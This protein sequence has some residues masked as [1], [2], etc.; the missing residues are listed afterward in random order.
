M[1]KVGEADTE[2]PSLRYDHVKAWESSV[3]SSIDVVDDKVPPKHGP[4]TDQTPRL[5]VC[6]DSKEKEPETLNSPIFPLKLAEKPSRSRQELPGP[7]KPFS[8]TLRPKVLK[9][10]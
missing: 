7:L 5:N 1:S 3:V 9:G 2:N 8:R 4:L 6:T 10:T